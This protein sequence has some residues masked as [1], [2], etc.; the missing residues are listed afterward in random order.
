VAACGVV[1]PREGK[2][3]KAGRPSSTRVEPELE[4]PVLQAK[5]FEYCSARVTEALLR[6]SADQI[7]VL[8]R[9]AANEVEGEEGA[10][11]SF[12]GMV[13]LATIRLSRTLD[14]PTLAEFT[15]KY[16]A[17]PEAFED[18]FLGLW[19]SGLGR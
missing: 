2:V 16:R 6:L 10:A 9:E 15:E 14:L 12:E 4:D 3:K 5:Y 1:P 18:E 13:R 19:E 17:N 7:Y 11:P 8:A